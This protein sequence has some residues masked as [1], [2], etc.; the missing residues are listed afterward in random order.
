MSSVQTPISTE[1]PFVGRGRELDHLVRLVLDPQRCGVV[2]AGSAGVGKTRIAQEC[3]LAAE[4]AGYQ[5]ARATATTGQRDVPLAA[6]THL[7][8]MLAVGV[9]QDYADLLRRARVALLEQVGGERFVLLVDD[10]HLLDDTSATLVYQLMVANNA[11][12]ILTMRAEEPASEV[13]VTAWKDDL[14]ERMELTG[15]DDADVAE[16][17]GAVLGH[18]DPDAVSVLADQSEQNILVLRELVIGAVRDGTLAATDGLWR[19]CR[20]L[21]PSARLIEL[22]ESRLKTLDEDDRALAEIVAVGEPLTLG[23][24]ARVADPEHAERLERQGLLAC[25]VGGT[26]AGRQ[27][28]VRLAHSIYGEVL[29]ARLPG[30]R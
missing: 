16:L 2:I 1:W 23:E 19:L 18:V 13:L 29:R 21:T 28:A 9:A 10:A 8:P 4:V 30:L 27:V 14:V 6:L 17:L 22:I 25:E 5:V 12:V 7:I 20:P 11:F 3:L 15:L 24:L 26:T